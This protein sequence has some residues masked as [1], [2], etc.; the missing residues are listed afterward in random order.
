[1]WKCPKCEALIADHYRYCHQCG[2]HPFVRRTETTE[3]LD[4]HDDDGSFFEGL[5]TPSFWWRRV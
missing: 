1:M 2:R 4:E 3:A 5:F